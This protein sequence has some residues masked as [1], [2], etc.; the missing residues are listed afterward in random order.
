[1]IVFIDKGFCKK[2]MFFLKWIYTE[3]PPIT[4]NY[5]STEI[6]DK[7]IC[8]RFY[9]KKLSHF[10]LSSIH[11]GITILEKAIVKDDKRKTKNKKNIPSTC[12]GGC[13]GL[14]ERGLFRFQFDTFFL[15]SSCG[16]LEE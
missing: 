12:Q 13:Q 15:P 10:E 7:R 6:H 8:S 4:I 2:E 16:K 11:F 1:M 9:R 3:S 14:K 5:K